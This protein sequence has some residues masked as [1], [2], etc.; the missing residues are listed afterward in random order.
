MHTNTERCLKYEHFGVHLCILLIENTRPVFLCWRLRNAE[1]AS[2]ASGDS[3]KTF[4]VVNADLRKE[5]A[6]ANFAFQVF[7]SSGPTGEICEFSDGGAFFES[8]CE[9]AEKNEGAPIVSYNGLSYVFK[10]LLAMVSSTVSEKVVP[11]VLDSVC[12]MTA[13]FAEHGFVTGR[14]QLGISVGGEIKYLCDSKPKF[15]HKSVLNEIG[16]LYNTIC[17]QYVV[18]WIPKSC[19]TRQRRFRQ[20]APPL[21]SGGM[22]TVRQ[23]VDHW[24]AADVKPGGW[25]TGKTRTLV[26][27]IIPV[28]FLRSEVDGEEGCRSPK[29]A[30]HTE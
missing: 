5:S 19:S 17:N 8:L 23:C 14:R 7:G 4:I 18:S 13:F 22:M 26:G 21:P 16:R 6:A 30:K 10:P 25:I 12:V 20:W 15:D 2:D 28:E 27:G 3:G 9:A 11:V 29:R 1:M 24:N